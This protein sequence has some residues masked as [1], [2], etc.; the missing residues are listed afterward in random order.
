ML[1]PEIIYRELKGNWREV[2]D[3]ARTTINMEKGEGEPSKEWKIRMLMAEHSPI[4]L[5]KIKNKWG[6]LKSW[7]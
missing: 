6:N 5:L 7:I 1:K 4:R 2:A 3:A